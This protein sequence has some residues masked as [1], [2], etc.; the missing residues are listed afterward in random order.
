MSWCVEILVVLTA[1]K[2]RI[3]GTLIVLAF[4]IIVLSEQFSMSR[5]FLCF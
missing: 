2:L 5:E 1:W 3:V 4:V